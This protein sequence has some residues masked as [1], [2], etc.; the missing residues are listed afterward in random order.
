MLPRRSHRPLASSCLFAGLLLTCSALTPAWAQTP[1]VDDKGAAELASSVKA[2][3]AQWLQSTNS[4]LRITWKGEVKAVPSG[5][6][7]AV[8]LPPL[9]LL[10]N[11]GVRIELGQ[12]DLQM[13]PRDDGMQ[14]VKVTF[15]NEIESFEG[16][17]PTGKLTIGSQ[18]TDGIWA[19]AYKTFVTMESA[20]SNLTATTFK[21][22]GK[23]A[24]SH[25]TIGS[26]DVKFDLK[27][28]RDDIWSGPVAVSAKD[29]ASRDDENREVLSISTMT[30][31]G[32]Y[33][34][35]N[36]AQLARLGEIGEQLEK[37]DGAEETRLLSELLNQIKGLMSGSNGT[38]GV[39]NIK[40]LDTDDNSTVSIASLSFNGGVA[41]L[42]KPAG[43]A[44]MGF[45]LKGLA[46]SLSPELDPFLP[47]GAGLQLTAANIPP[48]A[49]W[50]TLQEIIVAPEDSDIP[51][52]AMMALMSAFGASG[53][54]LR[55]ERLS[56]DTA[57]TQTSGTGHARVAPT[58][59]LGAVG[60][61]SFI[62]RG[63]DEAI[64]AIQEKGKTDEDAQ[65]VLSMLAMTQLWGQAATDEQGRPIRRYD[66]VLTN[67]GEMT[68]NGT[69]LS[70]LLG[71]GS[72]SGLEEE[73]EEED[74]GIPG[75]S[76]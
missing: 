71:T 73:M 12:I 10:D 35:V 51:T 31:G 66:L 49:L 67:E 50:Q 44:T 11:D 45:D 65:E 48:D 5:T 3:F 20:Y 74:E 70:A 42:D 40:V 26:V 24:D 57:L 63:L 37:A 68:L 6:F 30:M 59:A 23:R 64:K 32:A 8:T 22:D 56:V 19:P 4:P 53:A 38:F 43:S 47:R 7:Y 14:S 16:K 41:D 36:L 1:P 17:V 62:V 9:S 72:E 33:N 52:T 55:L 61:A 27:R 39:E 15:P 54:E 46:M 60:Q 34:H 2:G 58:A 29:I 13:T 18:R 76:E 21:E 69:D 25:T 28:D 75:K